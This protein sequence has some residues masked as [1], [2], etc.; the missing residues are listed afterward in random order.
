M[1]PDGKD[2]LIGKFA[3]DKDSD[4]ILL[5]ERDGELVGLRRPD[6]ATIHQKITPESVAFARDLLGMLGWIETAC[7]RPYQEDKDS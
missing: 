4:R 5:L 1:T 2:Y 7:L 3:H 6:G